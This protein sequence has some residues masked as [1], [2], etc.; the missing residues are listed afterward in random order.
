MFHSGIKIIWVLHFGE[1]ERSH[2]YSLMGKNILLV[3]SLSTTSTYSNNHFSCLFKPTGL[4]RERDRILFS[5]AGTFR[6]VA[7]EGF[8]QKCSGADSKYFVRRSTTVLEKNKQ[9]ITQVKGLSPS[10]SLLHKGL[11]DSIFY[12][13]L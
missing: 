8:K 4:T 11:L 13:I 12:F 7:G 1:A 10:C 5:F 9:K 2:Q 6:L 3:Y